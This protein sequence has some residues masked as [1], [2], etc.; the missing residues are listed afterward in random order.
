MQRV[1]LVVS[2]RVQGVG[3]RWYVRR[4]GAAL[5]L[6]GAVWNRYDGAV[7]IEAEGEREALERLIDAVREGPRA[8]LVRAVDVSWSEGSRRYR[9]FE[10]GLSP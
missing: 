5:G 6:T 7:E 2:G 1:H 9:D 4:E 10:I 3:F 8:A